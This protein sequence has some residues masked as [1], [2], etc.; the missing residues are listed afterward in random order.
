[1]TTMTFSQ[2]LRQNRRRAAKVSC[3]VH[4]QLGRS[5]HCSNNHNNSPHA[6]MQYSH[7][8]VH[9]LHSL[10]HSASISARWVTRM[11]CYC[12]IDVI[13]QKWSWQKKKLLFIFN[14][15]SLDNRYLGSYLG[16]NFIMRNSTCICFGLL[17]R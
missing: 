16:Y 6:V 10:G 5:A 9:D 2:P 4:S 17:R 13:E 12:Q 1:M 3:S 15:F 11:Y 8:F 7:Y 14:A